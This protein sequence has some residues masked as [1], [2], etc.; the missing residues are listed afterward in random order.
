MTMTSLSGT[1]GA[2][3]VSSHNCELLLTTLADCEPATKIRQQLLD[4]AAAAARARETWLAAAHALGD[5]TTDTRGYLSP[6]AAEISDL[7]LW[8]GRL[9]FANPEWTPTSGPRRQSRPPASLISSPQ[10]LQRVVTAV[11]YVC[12]TLTSLARTSRNQIREAARAS[13]ILV[14]TRTL[15]GSIDI[16]HAIW[17]APHRRVASVLSRYHDAAAASN[18]T[19]AEIAVLAEAVCSP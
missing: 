18:Q 4:G 12:D 13:R 15:P 6:V 5:I 8:T 10:D 17:P 19:T 3:T 14:P 7:A 16:P 9:A 2:A 1:A 11:H